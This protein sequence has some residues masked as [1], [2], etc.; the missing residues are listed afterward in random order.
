MKSMVWRPRKGAPEEYKKFQK[1]KEIFT[2]L[3]TVLEEQFCVDCAK[4]KL[5]TIFPSLKINNFFN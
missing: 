2:F 4:T 5:H 1:F 3:N